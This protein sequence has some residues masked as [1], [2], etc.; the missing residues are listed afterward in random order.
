MKINSEYFKLNK[1]PSLSDNKKS[2]E[3]S[4]RE[5]SLQ[6]GDSTLQNGTDLDKGID[7]TMTTVTPNTAASTKGAGV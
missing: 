5:F 7:S 6:I 1:C 3:L 4:N 2:E